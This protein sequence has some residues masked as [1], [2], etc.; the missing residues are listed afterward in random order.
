MSNEVTVAIIGLI[1]VLITAVLGW[2]NGRTRSEVRA[3]R[4]VAAEARAFAEPTGNGFAEHMRQA[5]DRIENG[6]AELRRDIGGLRAENRADRENS[7]RVHAELRQADRDLHQ[8][9]T[10]HLQRGDPT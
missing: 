5:L 7:D 3:T 1:G 8:R 6:N 10:D 4:K 9:I 2:M